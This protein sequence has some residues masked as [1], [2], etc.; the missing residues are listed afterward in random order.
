MEHKI[1]EIANR[2]KELRIITGLTVED[3]AS[4]T[5]MSVEEY[6]QCEAGNR[7]LSIA[8]LYHCTLSFG[9]DMGDILEGK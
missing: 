3:M 8:F 7:N 6:E 1:K 2:I 5:G 4:R 9:V